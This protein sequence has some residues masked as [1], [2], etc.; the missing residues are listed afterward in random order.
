VAKKNV[1]ITSSSAKI[2]LVNAVKEAVRK[3]DIDG[4]VYAG[5]A[6]IEAI[7]KYFVDKFWV[8]PRLSELSAAGLLKYCLENDIRFII[9]TR[10]GELEYFANIRNDFYKNGV[11]IMVPQPNSVKICLDKLLFFEQCSVLG[12]PIITTKKNIA[13]VNESHR[14]VVKEQ[15]GAGS[16]SIGIDL[17]K[18]EAI[19][20]AQRL[21][22]PVF[23][24][25]IQGKEYSIDVF[26]D[27][28]NNIKGAVARERLVVRNGESKITQICDKKELEN[29][30]IQIALAFTLYGHSVTQI[31]LDEYDMPHIVECNSR[32][33]GASVLSVKYG[34]DTFY[35][36]LMGAE[37]NSLSR[38]FFQ[39]G[40]KLLKMIRYE[41][42]LII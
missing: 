37:Q 19:K 23:Q 20:Y 1:L 3:A 39:K 31:I 5:D 33:G 35:W 18:D 10:D 4:L 25:Y 6:N 15:F 36:F 40:S 13:D 26:L 16:L 34:L 7:S 38:L 8:M 2:P 29:I 24:P 32:F 42:D 30:A 21:Q 22:A 28:T 14:F 11:S 9:P 17:S 12:L 27:I 41:T